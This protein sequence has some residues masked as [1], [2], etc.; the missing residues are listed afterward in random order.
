MLKAEILDRGNLIKHL[1]F[2]K[3]KNS[4]G[5]YRRTDIS[6][7]SDEE[8]I[9]IHNRIKLF[10]TFRNGVPS[11]MEP[12]NESAWNGHDRTFEVSNKNISLMFSN[13]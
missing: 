10:I 9:L 2:D 1:S 3:I 7:T 6:R 5:V 8:F 13:E 11:V 4:N 12:L